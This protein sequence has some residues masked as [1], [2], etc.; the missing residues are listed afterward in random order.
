MTDTTREF[1]DPYGWD[2]A[3]LDL[4]A[5]LKRIGY[6]GPLEPSLETLRALNWAH[7][8]SIPFEDVDVVLG[9]GAQLD[10]DSLQDKLVRRGRGGYCYEQNCLFGAVLERLGYHVVGLNARVL[11]GFDETVLR[12]AG[13][14]ALKIELDGR[15]WFTDV[16]VGMYGPL[17]PVE[18]VDGIEVT[19]GDGWTYRLDLIDHGM[20]VLRLR[21]HDGW[22]NVHKFS[23]EQFYRADYVD[24]N[25]VAVHH[26]RSPFHK[27]VIASFNGDRARHWL[28]GAEMSVMHAGQPPATRRLR[29]Q[30]L[31]EVLE[32]VF[33]LKLDAQDSAEL[34]RGADPEAAVDLHGD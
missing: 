15:E 14:T 5:Y 18:L 34:V 23:L 3:L 2:G 30:E 28:A 20:W 1:A 33:G 9:H 29:P 11:G 27:S 13:H 25:Y 7:A 10:M 32:E 4:D 16:G 22:F 19:Q 17:E 12:A 6:D 21:L 31:P 24:A 8:T 26:P